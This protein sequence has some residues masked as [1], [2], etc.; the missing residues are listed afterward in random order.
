MG[1]GYLVGFESPEELA[2]ILGERGIDYLVTDPPPEATPF[3]HWRMLGGWLDGEA[4]LPLRQI[5][6][7]PS[8]RRELESRFSIYRVVD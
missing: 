1:R 8:W 4:P 2:E 3:E 7:V 6:V 5:G